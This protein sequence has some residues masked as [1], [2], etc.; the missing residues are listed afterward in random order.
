LNNNILE[1]SKKENYHYL[2]GSA[3]KKYKHRKNE[4]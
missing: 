1:K 3:Q 2:P 4:A